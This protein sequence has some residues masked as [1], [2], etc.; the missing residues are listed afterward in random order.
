MYVCRILVFS[1]VKVKV[2]KE[3]IPRIFLSDKWIDG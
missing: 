1:K 3:G 2:K